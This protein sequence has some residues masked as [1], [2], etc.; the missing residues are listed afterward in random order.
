MLS[1]SNLLLVYDAKE[2]TNFCIQNSLILFAFPEKPVTF[3]V[4][5][6]DKKIIKKKKVFYD[7]N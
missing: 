3:K 5:A 2:N 7:I 1:K 6:K 4:C